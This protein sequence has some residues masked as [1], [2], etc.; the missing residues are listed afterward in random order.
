MPTKPQLVFAGTVKPTIEEERVFDA[1]L[2]GKRAHEATQ[3]VELRVVGGWV[4][5][6]LLSQSPGDIDV[7]LSQMTGQQFARELGEAFALV[8]VNP[9]QSKHLETAMV[10]L[11]ERDVDLTHMRSEEYLAHSRIPR[12]AVGTPMQDALRRDCT[13]NALYYNLES[14]AV[15]DPTGMGLRDLQEGVIRTPTTAALTLRDDPLRLL[16]LIRFAATLG[17]RLHEELVEA[18]SDKQVLEGLRCKISRERIRTEFDKMMLLHPEGCAAAMHSIEQVDK[19]VEIILWQLQSG[20]WPPSLVEAVSLPPRVVAAVPSLK[21][22]HATRVAALLLNADPTELEAL[23]FPLLKWSN[24][25]ART[26]LKLIR[27]SQALRRLP[28][29][30]SLRQAGGWA[31][32]QGPEL[33]EVTLALTAAA[34]HDWPRFEPLWQELKSGP[35]SERAFLPPLLRGDEIGRARGLRGPSIGAALS[36][37]IEWQMEAPTL[38]RDAALEH[39]TSRLY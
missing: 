17:F 19:L 36:D 4:R 25:H 2:E 27:G 3:H 37:L 22:L 16:R 38:S 5:D 26:V 24:E 21:V 18:F 12:V 35:L 20:T 29:R 34:E 1:L 23:A 31:R 11:A 15:E 28:A 13:V 30:P 9:E 14:R 7:C 6:K 8:S 39:L 10:R 33:W 32:Q